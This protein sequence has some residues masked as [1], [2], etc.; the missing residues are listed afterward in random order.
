MDRLLEKLEILEKIEPNLMKSIDKT[1]YNVTKPENLMKWC[2]S[3]E[4]TKSKCKKLYF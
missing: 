4:S 1:K 2:L 3:P